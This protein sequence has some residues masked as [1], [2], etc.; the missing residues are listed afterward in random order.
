[1]CQLKQHRCCSRNKTSSNTRKPVKPPL[2]SERFNPVLPHEFFEDTLAGPL[3]G[4]KSLMH[5]YRGE[6]FST[7]CFRAAFLVKTVKGRR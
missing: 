6:R 5:F 7:D 4:R 1:M 3:N 2:F